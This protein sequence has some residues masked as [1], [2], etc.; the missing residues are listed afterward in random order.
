MYALRSSCV[1]CGA[2]SQECRN[3][4]LKTLFQTAFSGNAEA[5]TTLL[6]PVGPVYPWVQ[7]P[8]IWETVWV[9]NLQWKAL[10]TLWMQQVF[11]HWKCPSNTSEFVHSLSRLKNPPTPRCVKR[12]HLVFPKIE[13]SLPTLLE[14]FRIPPDLKVLPVAS[15]GQ[16]G[17]RL[18]DG[19]TCGFGEWN[20]HRYQGLKV[21]YQILIN[22]GP[23]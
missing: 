14:G 22:L 1:E 21:Q 8:W 18:T 17:P 11:K 19:V 16:V 12:A 7:N 10:L 23:F 3:A 20:P 9:P 4:V 5:S 15:G 13:S 6:E 2:Y